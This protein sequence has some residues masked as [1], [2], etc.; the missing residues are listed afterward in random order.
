MR[1]KSIEQ[2]GQDASTRHAPKRRSALGLRRPRRPSISS[3]PCSRAW[4]SAAPRRSIKRLAPYVGGQDRHHRERER[5]LVRRLHQRRH[6]R[7]VGRLRQRRR[8]APHPRARPDRGQGGDPDL[9]ADHP[10]GLGPSRARRRRSAVATRRRQRQ[11]V[12]LPIDLRTGDRLHRRQPQPPS[13]S[14]SGSI[15]GAARRDAVPPRVARA[16]LRLPPS[17]YRRG[18]DGD[19]GSRRPRTGP[20]SARSRKRRAGATSPRQQV[21]RPQAPSYRVPPKTSSRGGTTRARGGARAASIPIISGAL[22]PSTREN[23]AHASGDGP[24]RRALDPG[25]VL[26]CDRRVPRQ[27][28][29]VGDGARRGA[30]GARNRRLQR[31]PGRRTDRPRD[32]AHPLR[33]LGARPARAE[34]VLEPLSGLRGADRQ[35]HRAWRD[36]AA[37]RQAAHVR[38]RGALRG[39]EAAGRHRPRPLCNACV[40]GKNRP[41][42]QATAPSRRR[43]PCPTRIPRTR[44]QQASR[45]ALVR[46]RCAPKLHRVP[47]PA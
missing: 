5:R 21:Q 17:R 27:G 15:L 24:A 6:G 31:P 35:R 44:L 40:P 18:A 4:S 47:L 25:A 14:I 41:V 23:G 7:G 10:G 12:A 26:R 43:T 2:N 37:S 33:G 46:G 39:G 29:A 16:G 8:Q 3:R 42:D 19:A 22:K 36:E 9:R 38:G 32:R 30:A 34:A 11:L 20:M 13:S 1:S 28:R 45:P